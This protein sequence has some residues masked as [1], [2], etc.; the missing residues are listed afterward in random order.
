VSNNG[1][2]ETRTCNLR[3]EQYRTIEQTELKRGSIE[4]ISR[5]SASGYGSIRI[6][7][8]GAIEIAF[9]PP[10]TTPNDWR[11]PIA[12]GAVAAFFETCFEWSQMTYQFHPYY[13]TD[14]DRWLAMTDASSDDPGFEA[15]LKSGMA[16]VVVPVLPGHERAVILYLKSGLVWGGGYL[17]LFDSDDFLEV[18]ADVENGTQLDPPIQIGESWDIVLPTT[19]IKLQPDDVLPEFPVSFDTAAIS[20]PQVPELPESEELPF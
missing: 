16:Q 5:A 4:L 15:F 13:W 14:R 1:D 8:T 2:R 18:F 19:M 20:P 11:S 12:N 3:D 7:L 6:G 9:D 10:S 17:P